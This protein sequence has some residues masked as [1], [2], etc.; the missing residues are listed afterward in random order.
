MKIIYKPS[1]KSE[2]TGIL[3]A[4]GFSQCFFKRIAENKDERFVTKKEHSHAGYE[5]HILTRGTQVYEFFGERISISGGEFLLI[6]P[7]VK[8]KIIESSFDVCKYG[9]TFTLLEA[10]GI[11]DPNPN[12][13]RDFAP[14]EVLNL[15]ENIYAESKGAKRLSEI[16]IENM[17]FELLVRILRAYGFCEKEYKQETEEGD[18]RLELAKKYIKDNIESTL[19]V[20]DV[21]SY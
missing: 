16:L 1:E 20:S 9:I 12:T 2:S 10:S 3:N 21:A 19:T 5:I 6:P 14:S 4:Y 15:C 18:A 17:I 8:H 7:K 13:V 11:F